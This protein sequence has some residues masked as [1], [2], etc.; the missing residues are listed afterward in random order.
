MTADDIRSATNSILNHAQVNY[1]ARYVGEE[2]DALGDV[3]IMDRWKITFTSFSRDSE[4]DFDFYTG[5]G[6][7]K[8][9]EPVSPHAADVLHSL[10]LDMLTVGQSFEVWCGGFGYDSDSRKALATHRS[11][12][13]N[14]NK[15][16]RIFN[17]NDIAA[18][19]AAL[20]E[21]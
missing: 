6:L 21:Y 9:A 12:Q 20:Q 2:R 1:I 7:R 5:L 13:R 15:L 11:C 3:D 19:E 10:I 4:Q 8:Q 14:A 18:L 17:E 16:R